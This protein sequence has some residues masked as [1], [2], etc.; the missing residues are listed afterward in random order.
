MSDT[1]MTL[2]FSLPWPPSV[3]HYWQTGL[4]GGKR[5][6]M[7]ASVFLSGAG[8]KYRSSAILSLRSQNVPKDA[9]KGRLAAH[10][11]ANPP[12][13]RVRDLDNI[14]KGCLDAM[15]HAGVIHDDGDIDDLHIVRGLPLRDGRLQVELREL[16]RYY[17]QADLPLLAPATP[18]FA[19][20]DPF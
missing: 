17:D 10:I 4:I 15:K 7:R 12:D 6:K 9:L 16:G 1:L 3:N 18:Q 8:K 2:R 19:A 5:V 13:A 20:G 11:V 14:V